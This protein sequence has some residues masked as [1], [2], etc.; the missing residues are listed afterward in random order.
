MGEIETPRP[1]QKWRGHTTKHPQTVIVLKITPTKVWYSVYD[2]P[3]RQ[4]GNRMTL[5][6]AI[7]LRHYRP[8]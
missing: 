8:L 5:G 6:T 7:F 4:R 1:R 3:G 2:G